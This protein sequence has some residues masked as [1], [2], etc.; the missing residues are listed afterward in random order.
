MHGR[1]S[2]LISHPS[3]PIG[4]RSSVHGQLSTVNDSEL[5]IHPTHKIKPPR[6]IPRVIEIPLISQILQIE[7]ELHAIRDFIF[8]IKINH[9]IGFNRLRHSAE[10]ELFSLTHIP[11]LRIHMCLPKGTTNL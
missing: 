4:Q 6:I 1:L 5:H 8:S 2:S 11:E 3:S 9:R 7:E 10:N